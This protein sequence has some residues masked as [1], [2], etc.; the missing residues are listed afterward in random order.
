ML[1][2][3]NAKICDL[4]HNTPLAVIDSSGTI[5]ARYG[6]E[7][8][9]QVLIVG[10][11]ITELIPDL[12][13]ENLFVEENPFIAFVDL[14][15]YTLR[16]DL[17]GGLLILVNDS[18]I[19]RQCTAYAMEREMFHSI[20][21][22][23][24]EGMIYVD[25]NRI[26][27]Y[28]NQAFADYNHTTVEN[29]IGHKVDEFFH[30][31][32]L[33]RTLKTRTLQPLAYSLFGNRKYITSRRP[34]YKKNN[35]AGVFSKYLSIDPKDVEKKYGSSYIDMIAG[36][37]TRDIMSNVSQTIIELDSYKDEFSQIHKARRGI[38][39]I[40]G[41]SSIISDLKEKVLLIADSPSTVL[42]TGE[43]GTGKELFAQAIHF[44]GGRFSKPF[45]R[46]N[47]AAIPETLLESELFGYVEGAFTG[48]RKGGK[49]GK[50][51]LANGGTIFLDEIG[52]MPM[53][54]QAKL[55]RVLQEKE[56]ERLG[57]ELTI[58]IDVRVITATNKDL[59]ALVNEGSFREDLYYR[60]N[61][62]NFNMPP[63]RERKEDIPEIVEYGMK[64]MNKNLNLSV[65]RFSPEVLDV[66]MNYDWPGN[67]RELKNVIESAMNFCKGSTVGVDAL[68]NFM[69]SLIEDLEIPENIHELQTRIDSAEKEQLLEAMKLCN[70]NRKKI[71]HRLNVSKST[72][73]RLMKKHA[74]L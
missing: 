64:E 38:N 10:S 52:D 74:L 55:L 11:N 21:D 39:N 36:L 9:V 46:V 56:I 60:V 28:V 14:S 63:L 48:A 17:A 16:S 73:Y 35:F 18:Y 53:A 19:H 70:G 43:S 72:L 37:Q 3:Y 23:R 41:K 40:I 47:C 71:A 20:L 34:V 58:P 6:S 25:E 67:I 7:S 54:M 65:L 22:S 30:D 51:E 8:A 44:H 13:L 5:V 57:S 32:D 45:I 50:F 62:I 26:I 69:R 61:V 2:K 27:R 66:F 59:L 15:Q 1:A 49:M 29:M 42:L 33:D 12:V 68:P 4:D 24:Y 31:E